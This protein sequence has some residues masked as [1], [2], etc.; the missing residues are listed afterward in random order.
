MKWKI[1]DPSLARVKREVP[2]GITPFPC[3]PRIFGHRFVLGDAQN[4]HSGPRHCG[5]YPGTTWS[6]GATEVTPSPTDSTMHPASWPRIE[7]KIPSG[8]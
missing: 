7:G 3:V 1:V 6:P 8:S 5:V 2:S 4:M